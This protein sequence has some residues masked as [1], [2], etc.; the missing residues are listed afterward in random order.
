MTPAQSLQTCTPELKS[1]LG[2]IARS[3]SSV[4]LA[5]STTQARTETP[6]QAADLPDLLE[7]LKAHQQE[8]QTLY[9]ALQCEA[10]DLTDEQLASI[11]AGRIDIRTMVLT[12]AGTLSIATSDGA[13][14]WE[15]SPEW[16]A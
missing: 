3:T 15:P 2:D 5:G 13:C 1:L 4:R 8:I 10:A 11:A 14:Y 6:A 12:L 16:W 7:K 9:A